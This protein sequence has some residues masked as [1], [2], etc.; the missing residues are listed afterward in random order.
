[1]MELAN[2]NEG[3][4][5][6]AVNHKGLTATFADAQPASGSQPATPAL[7]GPFNNEMTNAVVPKD[8]E[9]VAGKPIIDPFNSY[10]RGSGL[11]LGL[12]TMLPNNPDLNQLILAGI[13]EQAA[14]C[15]PASPICVAGR[16]PPGSGPN[17]AVVKEVGPI[18][19]D[20]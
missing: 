15:S 19:G 14:P 7:V 12:G 2:V 9:T 17:G 4:S 5:G 20:P 8:M 16:I 3:F 13:A 1:T 18:P 6:A 10:A 11:E